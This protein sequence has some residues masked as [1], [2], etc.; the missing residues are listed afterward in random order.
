[1]FGHLIKYSEAY[2]ESVPE[3]L[4]D[5]VREI[6]KEELVS[7]IVAIN[8]RINPVNNSHLDDS[9][10]TQ[11]D[12]LRMLFLDNENSWENSNCVYFLEKYLRTP[13]NHILFSRV[14]C[15]YALQEILNCS[16]FAIIVPT[17]TID[18]REKILK[19]LLLI[20][21]N[22]LSFETEYIDSG[23]EELGS[24]FF[25][26][27]MFKEIP[28]NQYYHSLDPLNLLEKSFTLLGK[29][30][31]D[32]IFGQHFSVYLEIKFG[33]T[34]FVEFFKFLAFTF[35]KSYDDKLKLNYVNINEDQIEYVKILD[36]FSKRNPTNIVSNND[37]KIFEFLELKKN[38]LFKT[39][40]HINP[41]I[42]SYLVLDNRFLLEKTYSLFINDFWFD[43]LK[44]NEIRTRADWG[45]FIGNVFFEPFI[46]EIFNDCF[47]NNKSTVFKHTSDLKL[48]LD[49]RNEI[50]Y[51]DYY[52]RQKNKIILAE[53]KSNFLPVINGYKTV[54]TRE[55]FESIDLEKFYKDYGLHQLVKKTLKE[56][57]N[58]KKYLKDNEFNF[59]NK[60]EIFP[61]LIV[62]DHIFSSGYTSMAF[63]IKCLDLMNEEG[64]SVESELHKIHP[65]TIINVADLQNIRISLKYGKQNIFN[66]FR[67]YH[68]TSG[69]KAIERTGD[70]SL[71]LL[72]VGRSIDTLLDRSLLFN[73]NIDWLQ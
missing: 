8:S 1:M 48:K 17:Y 26:F 31:E 73:R 27:F 52:I 37:L 34:S 22:I 50:E 15:L 49:N 36:G 24:R 13:K 14:T 66:I 46:E 61:T 25:D 55:D 56:F 3:I 35:F 69:F 28:Q 41:N 38:P 23:H 65:L 60:V 72:T 58:Y 39:Q 42:I 53:A 21:T 29:I 33:V 43:Y 67:H 70:S 64:I 2:N 59:E 32:R 45:S 9:R 30:N 57:H 51:A 71:A 44:E 47:K 54:N 7:T 40:N 16:D 62:N 20:N 68:S 4:S 11:I 63:K 10:E 6:P 5:L 18:L 12:C 19:F